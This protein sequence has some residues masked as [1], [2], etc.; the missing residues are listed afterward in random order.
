M[1]SET[2]SSSSWLA[3]CRSSRVDDVGVSKPSPGGHRQTQQ[4]VALL[5][6]R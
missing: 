3:P 1:F 5:G 6:K 4:A 2:A